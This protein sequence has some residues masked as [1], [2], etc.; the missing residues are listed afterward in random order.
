MPSEHYRR[1]ALKKA[2]WVSL[3]RRTGEHELPSLSEERQFLDLFDEERLAR[4]VFRRPFCM[5]HHAKKPGC[6]LVD[7]SHL[8]RES[9]SR[10]N[11]A[12]IR[13]GASC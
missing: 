2:I 13:P 6:Q 5:V 1:L 11:S 8:F 7:M 3:R 9:S 10:A 4:P 12:A